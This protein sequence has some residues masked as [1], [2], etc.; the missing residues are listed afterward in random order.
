MDARKLAADKADHEALRKAQEEENL[1][2][3][4]K[5]N[6]NKVNHSMTVSRQFNQ[7]KLD[8]IRKKNKMCDEVAK[9][10]SEKEHHLKDIAG[11]EKNFN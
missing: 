4:L 8:E 5:S 7:R 11:I 1:Q 6:E 9:S 2:R 3:M 10:Q